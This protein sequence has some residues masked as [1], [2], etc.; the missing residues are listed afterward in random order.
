MRLDWGPDRS[1]IS[2]P[3]LNRVE[4]DKLPPYVAHRWHPMCRESPGLKAYS[5]TGGIHWRARASAYGWQRR[6]R[7]RAG[8][9]SSTDPARSAS[10]LGA[11]SSRHPAIPRAAPQVTIGVFF[12]TKRVTFSTRTAVDRWTALTVPKNG[13]VVQSRGQVDGIVPE[14]FGL[15]APCP[16]DGLIWREAT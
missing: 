16:V 7:P 10:G 13:L 8:T 1:L 5:R 9:G 6:S 11:P 3:R 12:S 4:W 15:G 14:A 2:A